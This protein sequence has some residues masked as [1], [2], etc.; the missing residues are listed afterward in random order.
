MNC[1]KVIYSKSG[2]RVGSSNAFNNYEDALTDALS[3]SNNKGYLCII[4]AFDNK[5]GSWKKKCT[6][7]PNE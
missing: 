5:K 6:I 1:F 7:Y 4:L 2:K 3:S